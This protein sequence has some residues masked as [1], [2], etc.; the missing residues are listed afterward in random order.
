MPPQKAAATLFVMATFTGTIMSE[1]LG[2]RTGLNIVT[3]A[4]INYED[5]RPYKVVYL[6]HGLSD[7]HTCWSDNAQLPLF[8]NE[9]GVM[10]VIRRYSAVFIP[11][12]RSVLTI[13]PI[14]RKN[15]RKYV[16]GFWHF[17]CTGKHLHHGAVYG[18]IRCFESLVGQTVAIWRMC[19]FFGSL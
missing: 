13:I 19:R 2:M 6:L 12:W 15:C 9:Y 1:T 14:S 7:S 3:P 16:S 10:F 8:S 5:E 4:H 17:R 11:I 18:W